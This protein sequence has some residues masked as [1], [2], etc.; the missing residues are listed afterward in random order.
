MIKRIF[1]AIKINPSDKLISVINDI[2]KSLI[3]ENI[4]WVNINNIHITLRFFGEI[5]TSEIPKI[6]E[7]YRNIANECKPIDIQLLGVGVFKNISNPQVIWLGITNNQNIN[8]LY[9]KTTSKI[10]SLGYPKEVHGFN[11]HLTVG[12]MKDFKKHEILKQIIEKYQNEV[13]HNQVIKEL[14]LF[15]SILQPQGAIYKIIEKYNLGIIN[16]I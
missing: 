9:H 15:E 12:R 2:N 4:R 13:I 8:A 7:I 5:E 11:P 10:E 16:K 3:N 14:I 6:S 1:S